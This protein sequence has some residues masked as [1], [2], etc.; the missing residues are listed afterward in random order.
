MVGW[1]YSLVFV[2]R[3]CGSRVGLISG[4]ANWRIYGSNL[5]SKQ[6]DKESEI[7]ITIATSVQGT[8]ANKLIQLFI[9]RVPMAFNAMPDNAMPMCLAWTIRLESWQLVYHHAP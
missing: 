6:H 5:L 2:L 7:K 9:M 1:G 8:S 3:I 4:G